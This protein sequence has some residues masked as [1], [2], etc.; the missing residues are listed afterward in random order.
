MADCPVCGASATA[1]FGTKDGHGLARCCECGALFVDP[2]PSDDELAAFYD[3]YGKTRQYQ[4]KVR[5]KV[6]RARRRIRRLKRLT[7][8]RRFIDVGCNVGFA[9]A[10]A[11]TCGFDALGIDIDSA[12]IDEAR[13]LFPASRFAHCDAASVEGDF[14]VAYCSEVVEH[15]ADPAA[16]LAAIRRKLAAGGLLYLTTPDMAH[17]SVPRATGALL[18]SEAIK[19]PEHLL[20]LDKR[21]VQALLRRVG[22][23]KV[24][25]PI[26]LNTTLKAIAWAR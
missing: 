16:F 4:A 19:P 6:R 13:A 23:G 18:A 17:A 3:R 7:P 25:F 1:P 14:D 12:A 21:S 20:Y 9:V 5:S 11:R 26:S 22:F 8:G 10:A 15:L 24:R 2:M